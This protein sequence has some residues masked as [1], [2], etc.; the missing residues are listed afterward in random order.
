[1]QNGRIRFVKS[2]NINNLPY[3]DENLPKSVNELGGM[4]ELVRSTPARNLWLI[5]KQFNVLPNDPLIVNMSYPIREFIINSMLL[6]VEESKM[7]ERGEESDSRVVDKTQNTNVFE[8][9]GGKLVEDDDDPDDIYEQV[10][11]KT[12]DKEYD[13]MLDSKIEASIHEQELKLDNIRR[14]Q[15]IAIKNMSEDTKR[16][17]GIKD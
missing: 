17:L 5:C 14:Q 1:M 15:E 3:W 12:K 8:A 6:D 9:G 13:R 4:S 2:K 11:A 10:K 16:A 7:A